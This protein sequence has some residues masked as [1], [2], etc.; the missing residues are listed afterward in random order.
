MS[1]ELFYIVDVNNG[2]IFQLRSRETHSVYST[3]STL[4]GMLN[5]FHNLLIK[6]KGERKLHDCLYGFSAHM[7]PDT[8]ES[9]KTEY[10][11]MAHIFDEDMEY[12]VSQASKELQENRKKN[13]PVLKNTKLRKKLVPKQPDTPHKKVPLIKKKVEE[14]PEPTKKPSILHRKPLLVKHKNR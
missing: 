2:D 13:N 6:Y 9:R 11:E 3:S 5:N 14:E 8:L 1:L 4:E 12:V 10:P 7:S